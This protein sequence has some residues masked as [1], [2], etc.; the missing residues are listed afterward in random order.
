MVEG[1]RGASAVGAVACWRVRQRALRCRE[2][3]DP[4]R[5]DPD[6]GVTGDVRSD[7]AKAHQVVVVRGRGNRRG[8]R[9]A[10]Q[11]LHGAG[12]AGR[13][14]TEGLAGIAAGARSDS[15]C[16]GIAG[17]RETDGATGVVCYH[18]LCRYAECW[19]NPWSV[20][21]AMRMSQAC[22]TCISNRA[23]RDLCHPG[24]ST[25]L[26]HSSIIFRLARTQHG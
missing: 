26:S 16:C 15:R 13:G 1:R 7:V 20:S 22:A 14:R 6:E 21:S 11:G 3:A 5:V 12:V 8:R 18:W 23:P 2:Q 4:G 25:T 19:T 24:N 17:R 9:R 10:G